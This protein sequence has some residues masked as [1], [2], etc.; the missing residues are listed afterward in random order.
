MRE[1]VLTLLSLV[2][3]V[4]LAA[5]DPYGVKNSQDFVNEAAIADRY[6]IE[7]AQL[8]RDRGNDDTRAVASRLRDDH[9]SALRELSR[10][11]KS[12]DLLV[13]QQVDP[14]HEALLVRL[15]TMRGAHFDR[16]F[17]RQEVR[18]NE[19]VVELYRRESSG[20][21]DTELVGYAREML[22]LQQSHLQTTQELAK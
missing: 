14:E 20:G 4:A 9:A 18:A 7:A 2:T 11:A 17:A 3:S 10:I 5:T 6:Q 19:D 8:A 16:E 22:S 15:G 21:K 12:Q 13:P 1:S